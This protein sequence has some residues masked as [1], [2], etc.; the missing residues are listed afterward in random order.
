M[1]IQDLA[2]HA[3]D[4]CAEHQTA[5]VTRPDGVEA[6][7]LEML[8]RMQTGR[9]KVFSHLTE[10]FEEFRMYHRKD[11]KIVKEM[12]DLLSSSRYAMMMKRFA[13]TKPKQMPPINYKRRQLA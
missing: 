9:W 12:D 13:I 5:M 10:W 3:A 8:D 7:V 6:G 11:G 2:F 4:C 1:K